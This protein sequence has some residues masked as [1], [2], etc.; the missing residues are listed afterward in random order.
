MPRGVSTSYKS[1]AENAQ[2]LLD[3]FDEGVKASSDLIREYA[4]LVPRAKQALRAQL[5]IGVDVVLEASQDTWITSIDS[6]LRGATKADF[7]TSGDV[8][9]LAERGLEATKRLNTLLGVQAKI[10]ND[11]ANYIAD[12]DE[13]YDTL[14]RDIGHISSPPPRGKATRH[15][16]SLQSEIGTQDGNGSQASSPGPTPPQG[17][18]SAGGS[19]SAGGFSKPQ[20]AK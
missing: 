9:E 16:G 11:L 14:L 10:I 5:M 12:A 6:S 18:N 20:R 1:K 17:E 2:A 7:S 15:I 4:T 8:A 3:K 13:K 19:G